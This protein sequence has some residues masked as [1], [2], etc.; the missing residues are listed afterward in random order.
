MKGEKCIL[1]DYIIPYCLIFAQIKACYKAAADAAEHTA[2]TD[3]SGQAGAGGRFFH[4]AKAFAAQPRPG[5]YPAAFFRNLISFQ[6]G[7]YSKK[8]TSKRKAEQVAKSGNING[9]RFPLLACL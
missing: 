3:Q 4:G 7:R 8:A 6:S 1:D 2:G 5:N 9:N